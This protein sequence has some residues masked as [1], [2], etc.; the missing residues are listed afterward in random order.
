ML[1]TVATHW[2]TDVVHSCGQHKWFSE[3]QKGWRPSLL[4]ATWHSFLR[5]TWH[6]GHLSD[7]MTSGPGP[8]VMLSERWPTCH[9]ARRKECRVVHIYIINCIS[10]HLARQ[11][12]NTEHK[13]QGKQNLVCTIYHVHWWESQGASLWPSGIGSCLGRN[14]LS[15]RFLAVSDIYPVFIEP[16]ITWVPSGFSGIHMTWHKNCV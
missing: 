10:A 15:V 12:N 7:N 16:T 4:Q 11:H 14:R 13:I 1:S 5:A 2:F 8:H 9:V 6:V 3:S